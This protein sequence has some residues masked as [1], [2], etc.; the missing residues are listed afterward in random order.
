[1]DPRVAAAR[2][3]AVLKAVA[4]AQQV[5]VA[6]YV[7]PSAARTRTVA[8]GQK[9][10]ASLPDSTAALL[11]HILT[12]APTKTAVLAMGTPYLTED[13]PGIENYICTF[14]NATVSEISAVRALFGEIPIPGHLPVNIPGAALS[15][16]PK[17]QPAGLSYVGSPHTDSQRTNWFV[18]ATQ[19]P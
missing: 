10:S 1:V 6:V 17:Q 8:R 13:F 16:V 18:R 12:R 5:V 4:Q 19:F 7:V 14:S 2:S 9:N 15:A 3:D 11:D